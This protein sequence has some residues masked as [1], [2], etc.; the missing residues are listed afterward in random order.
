MNT[1]TAIK[2]LGAKLGARKQGIADPTLPCFSM[3]A[4]HPRMCLQAPLAP[5]TFL[6]Y[7]HPLKPCRT[8][9]NYPSPDH[10]DAPGAP[11]GTLI[12]NLS[13]LKSCFPFAVFAPAY[14]GGLANQ[15]GKISWLCFET[16]PI[17]RFFS[18]P[19]I[20]D[21]V[22][23]SLSVQGWGMKCQ[24]HSSPHRSHSAWSNPP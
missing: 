8:H 18:P 10:R 4:P 20:P 19:P 2:G 5:S 7:S 24:A 14:K 3:P 15:P 22:R 21:N 23:H 12:S 17:L 16:S 9:S 6:L 13:A 11:P 1:I